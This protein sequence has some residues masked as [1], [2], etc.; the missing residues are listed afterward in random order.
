MHVGLVRL[1]RE[2]GGTFLF[3]THDEVEAMTLADRVAVMREG[4]LQQFD[5]PE[6]IY[7]EPATLGPRR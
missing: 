1:Q 3:V 4:S 6:T 2:L 5:R 7:A